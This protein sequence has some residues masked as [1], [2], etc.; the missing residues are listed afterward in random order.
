MDTRLD[1][2][3]PWSVNADGTFGVALTACLYATIAAP[4]IF[5]SQPWRLRP[6]HGAID[7][8]ADH[9]RQVMDIDPRGREL[10]ISLGAALLNLRIAILQHHRLPLTLL[11]PDPLQPDLVARIT[12]GPPTAPDTTVQA[13]A[14]AIPRRQTNRRPFSSVAIP[15]DVLDELAVAARTEG[16]TLTVPD[17][18]GCD[19]LLSVARSANYQLRFDTGYRTDLTAWT[20]SDPASPDG[21]SRTEFGPWDALETLPLRDFGLTRP[22][23]PRRDA[24][25]EPHPA[26]V[27]IATTGDTPEDWLRAGQALERVLLTATVRGVA[28]TPMTQPLEIPDLRELLT[29]PAGAGHPQVILRLGYGPACPRS[30]R[31][32]LSQILIQD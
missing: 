31:R 25:F 19:H 20:S 5:N 9:R 7:L 17:E 14:A 21:I 6:S 29:D 24:V 3:D 11:E 23:E 32:P 12:L 28:A 10:T 22:R 15:P 8:Y 26:L 27:V 13:L 18:I 16:A 1:R 30:G 4:S 2:A